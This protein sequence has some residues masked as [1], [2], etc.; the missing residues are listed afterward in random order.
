MHDMQ[1]RFEREIDEIVASSRWLHDL[2]Y[3]SSHGGN[4]SYRVAPGVV[5]VTPTKVAKQDVGFDDICI[6]DENGGILFAAPGRAPTGETPFHLR[7]LSR[8]PDMAAVVHAH[9]P[10]LTGFAIAGCDA[11]SR[12]ILP[13]PA[14]EVGPVVRV[15]YAEPLSDDLAA[16]FDPV[17][18]R[19]NAFLMEN[20]GVIVLSKDGTRRAVELLEMLEGMACSI[21]VARECGG[22]RELS[23]DD[24]GRLDR[25]LA[26]RK[27]ALPGLPGTYT[28][29]REAFGMQDG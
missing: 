21:L 2:K 18:E 11:L 4:L 12:P 7:I 19:A 3:V 6:I 14:I 20:H 13:E 17:V 29:L 15:P 16:A 9:P 10:I 22:V 26:K 25:V 5:L 27:N 24:V 28:A 8:R 1:K 23:P